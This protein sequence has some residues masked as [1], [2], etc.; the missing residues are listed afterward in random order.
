MTFGLLK[1]AAVVLTTAAT[2]VLLASCGGSGG[3]AEPSGTADLTVFAFDAKFDARDYTVAAG[4]IE[5]DYVSKSNLVHTLLIEDV[6]GFKL[7]VNARKK[8]NG[9]VALTAG[10]YTMYC[11]IPQ[12]RA[13]GMEATL[14]VT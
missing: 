1:S 4:T 5:V 10:T 6:A 9:P 2:M 3:S 13:N 7:Q 14:T 11:D 12:H 8:S